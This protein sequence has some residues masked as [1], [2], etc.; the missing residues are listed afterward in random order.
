MPVKLSNTLVHT[1]LSVVVSKVVRQ[2]YR[3]VTRYLVGDSCSNKS[4]VKEKEGYKE[5]GKERE[6]R[7]C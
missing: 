3:I 7:I 4:L 5:E 2:L 1:G 6:R